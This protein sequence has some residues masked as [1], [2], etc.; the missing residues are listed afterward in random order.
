MSCVLVVVTVAQAGLLLPVVAE[1]GTGEVVDGLGRHAQLGGE[2]GCG[3][4]P[5]GR[6]EAGAGEE[7]Q[8][9]QQGQSGEQQAQHGPLSSREVSKQLIRGRLGVEIITSRK[10]RSDK[11]RSRRRY[12]RLWKCLDAHHQNRIQRY[13]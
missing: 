10:Y 3:N 4:I 5:G 1:L 13:F 9:G 11:N 8:Q 6:V 12:G 2:V 7:G